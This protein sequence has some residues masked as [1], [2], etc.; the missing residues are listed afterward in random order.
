MNNFY[1][2]N[3]ISSCTVILKFKKY[4]FFTVF[5]MIGR[6]EKK[7]YEGKRQ[8]LRPSA[9][10]RMSLRIQWQKWKLRLKSHGHSISYLIHMLAEILSVLLSRK[11]FESFFKLKFLVELKSFFNSDITKIHLKYAF[12]MANYLSY[13]NGTQV[14]FMCLG[15]A[16]LQF[17]F[18]MKGNL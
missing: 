2:Y 1:R 5:A 3:I 10:C 12:T 16:F 13:N 9:K 14:C 4:S 15:G 18:T 6:R 17:T 7:I 11:I 8:S